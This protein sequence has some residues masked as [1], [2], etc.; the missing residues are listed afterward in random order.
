MTSQAIEQY[1]YIAE[2]SK[3][4]DLALLALGDV[5]LKLKKYD[6]AI[7]YYKKLI[8]NKP[9]LAAAY[10]NL[11]SAYGGSGKCKGRNG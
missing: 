3:D 10:A 6:D 9:G 2:H 5:S 1:K 8:K 7:K 4:A 11:A